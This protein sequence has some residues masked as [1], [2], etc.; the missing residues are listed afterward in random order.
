MEEKIIRRNE[1]IEIDLRRVIDAVL[2]KIWTVVVITVFSGVLAFVGTK[3]FV[4][5]LYKSKAMFYVNNKNISIGDTALSMSSGDLSVSRN[6]VNTYIVVLNARSTLMDVIDYADVDYTYSEIKSMISASSVDETEIFQVTVTSPDNIE[7]DRIA[8][9]IT[10]ILPK[11]IS[12]IIEGTSAKIVDTSIVAAAPS[13]PNTVKNAAL[14]AILGMLATVGLI[15]LIEIFDTTIRTEEDIQSVSTYP[16]LASIPDM[17]A[18]SKEGSYS[19][20]YDT[21]SK[22]KKKKKSRSDKDETIYIGKNVSFTASEAYRMLRTKVQFSFADEKSCYVVG[23]SSALA[24]EGKSITSSNLAYSMAQLNK[25]VLLVDCDMRKPSIYTKLKLENAPGLS[26]YLTRQSL[27]ED[28]LKEYSD[29]DNR[30]TFNVIT[31]GNQPPNPVELLSSSRMA[32]ALEKFKTEYEFIVLDLPPIGEVT[33][34]MA[35]A[36]HT[37]GMLIVSRMDYGDRNLLSDALKQFEFINARILGI[38]ATCTTESSKGYGYSKYGKGYYKKYY[39]YSKY[40]RYRGYYRSDKK[41]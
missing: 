40:N 1:E 28:I 34:A 9:A 5:P 25:K 6:L 29:T 3:Q 39:K 32:R 21:T 36:A 26:N 13:S 24:G 14:G 41:D 19:S 30:A 20:Y 7:A 10:Y 31:A 35:A 4:T 11:K 27:Y 37:D 15:A 8:D 12:S 16:I 18:N 38:V 2:K 17:N 33:D 23:V 22:S